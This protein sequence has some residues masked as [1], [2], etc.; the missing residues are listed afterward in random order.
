VD[1]LLGALRR[2]S[3]QAPEGEPNHCWTTTRSAR[4]CHHDETYYSVVLPYTWLEVENSADCDAGMRRLEPNNELVYGSLIFVY[5]NAKHS[6]TRFGI[7]IIDCLNPM[8]SEI[9]G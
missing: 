4:A 1:E 2:A 8:L 6:M 7:C 9:H 5:E 3:S